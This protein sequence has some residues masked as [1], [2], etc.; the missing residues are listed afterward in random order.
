MAR[1]KALLHIGVP[2]A[3]QL[4]FEVGA[5]SAAAWM[6]GL[7]GTVP[8]AA[9]QIALSCAGSTFTVPMGLS[10]AAGMRVSQAIGAGRRDTVRSIGYGSLGIAWLAM[11]FFALVFL[12]MGTSIAGLFVDDGS[13]VALAGRLLA[14]AGLFQ[15]FDGT[16]V[17][18]AGLLRGM[19]D[20][21]VPTVITFV[22]YWVVMIPLAYWWGVGGH[23]PLGVWGALV[24]GLGV[25]A[26]LLAW[27]FQRKTRPASAV[28]GP[29][30]S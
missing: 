15:L 18:G 26:V 9:H 1:L 25:S 30:T 10:L 20:M 14:V 19:S 27:R 16:Q 4:F 2:A 3:G 28:S 13:V 24:F 22:A 12:L 21:R 8:L 11:G 29:L 23:D 17:V 7:L 5:F 6:M